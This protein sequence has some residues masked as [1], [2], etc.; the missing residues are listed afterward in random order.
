M[1]KH[2]EYLLCQTKS[3]INNLSEIQVPVLY[4]TGS[5][6]LNSTALM[7]DRDVKKNTSAV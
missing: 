2:I 7:S 3:L 6:D 1:V 4:L 5:E